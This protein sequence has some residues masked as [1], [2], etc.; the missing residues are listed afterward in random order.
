MTNGGVKGL[1]GDPAQKHDSL[2]GPDDYMAGMT[3]AGNEEP[4]N[5]DGRDHDDRQTSERPSSNH[6]LSRT[7][8]AAS[9]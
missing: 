6:T 7:K 5:R 3:L 9:T 8:S 2:P 4:V 1:S